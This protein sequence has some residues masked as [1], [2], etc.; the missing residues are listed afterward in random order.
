MPSPRNTILLLMG[1]DSVVLR[2]GGVLGLLVP[3][4]PCTLASHCN[5]FA[6]VKV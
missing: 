3:D 6:K 5:Y 4:R 2:M 1:S